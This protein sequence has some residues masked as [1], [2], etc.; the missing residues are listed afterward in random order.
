MAMAR[1]S[2]CPCLTRRSLRPCTASSQRTWI[3]TAIP[4][5]CSPATSMDSS[6]RSGGWPPATA[7]CC[8]AMGRAPSRPCERRP[9]A[10]SSLDKHATSRAF[11]RRTAIST[12][13]RAT[14]TVHS[15]SD[16]TKLPWSPRVGST[17]TRGPRR[18]F[19]TTWP[20]GLDENH[21]VRAA[22]AVH[23]EVRGVLEHFDGL[24]V[25]WIDATQTAAGP[26]LNGNAIDHVERLVVTVER[27]DAAYTDGNPSAGRAGD[28]HSGHAAFKDLFDRLAGRW[29]D[30]VRRHRGGRRRGRSAPACFGLAA[31]VCAG[32]SK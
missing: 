10:S 8:E 25:V 1:S 15:Y 31:A 22:A 7:S 29:V 3:A 17:R 19:G 2:S 9:V 26:G 27:G 14:T 12:S 4:T 28:D 18:L 30:L 21:P 5:C 32:G 13:S 20:L 16:P 6:R 24:D 23:R 11:A